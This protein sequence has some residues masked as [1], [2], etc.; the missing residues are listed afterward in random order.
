MLFGFPD[1]RRDQYSP[2]NKKH[3]K[4]PVYPFKKRW[5]IPVTPCLAGGTEGVDEKE[6]KP[7]HKEPAM[8]K[9]SLPLLIAGLVVL[10]NV[11]V[12]KAQNLDLSH[13]VQANLAFDQQFNQWN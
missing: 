6:S 10:G 11:G 5:R 13:I 9:K 7:C 4:C 3:G 8:F 12:A 2:S 1:E